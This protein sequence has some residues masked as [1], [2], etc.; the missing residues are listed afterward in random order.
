[1]KTEKAVANIVLNRARFT[2]YTGAFG[3]PIAQTK[4]IAS[5]FR[6]E[7]NGPTSQRRALRFAV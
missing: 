7:S 6:C 1:M 4:K 5:R 2:S 3:D